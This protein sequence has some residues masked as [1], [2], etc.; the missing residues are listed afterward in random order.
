MN[1]SVLVT[2]HFIAGIA[3]VNMYQLL[4]WGTMWRPARYTDITFNFLL[5]NYYLFPFFCF[6]PDRGTGLLMLKYVLKEF[7]IEL[8]ILDLDMYP[9]IRSNLVLVFNCLVLIVLYTFSY[10]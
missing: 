5:I 3:I 1:V 6:K 7:Y 8:H 9:L 4:Y 10:I 2:C